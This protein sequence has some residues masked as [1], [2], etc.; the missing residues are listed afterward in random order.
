[1][2][3]A[4]E[5]AMPPH[6]AG[7]APWPGA[8]VFGAGLL[9]VAAACA[10][11]A[12]L[13]LP[14]GP[15]RMD[16][17][18]HL[19]PPDLGGRHPLGTDALG[20]DVFARLVYGARISLLVG[21]SAVAISAPVGVAVGLVAGYAGGRL[22][23]VLMRLADVQLAV[24]TILLTIAIVTVLGPGLSN[25]IISLSVTGWPTYARLV[26]GEVLIV[27]RQDYVDAARANGAGPLRIVLRH[28]LP[29]VL[30][31]AIVFATFAV[32]DTI[33]IEATLSFLGLGVPPRVVTWGSMLN[34]G[35]LYLASAWWITFFP[36]L[37]I[38]LTVL[39]TNLIGD[40]LRDRLDPHLRNL[41]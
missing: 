2:T 11:F 22:G 40:S 12:D 19:A 9:V 27:I 17:A 28:V 29:N 34:D 16:L 3:V 25:V 37:A 14:Q 30:T 10:I 41:L 35:R 15:N 8:L 18:R 38:F 32:G 24:P 1:M 20:R 33:I 13:L 5:L 21:L 6:R 31:P 7:R 26:R 39:G 36:G 23:N 4:D